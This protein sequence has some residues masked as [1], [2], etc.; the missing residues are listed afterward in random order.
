[1]TWRPSKVRL[2]VHRISGPIE[3]ASQCVAHCG[4]DTPT[5]RGR[6]A[7][8]AAVPT[9]ILR[10]IC[11]FDWSYTK[12]YYRLEY[13]SIIY[14]GKQLITIDYYTPLQTT[15]FF[16]KTTVQLQFCA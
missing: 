11:S 3:E 10:L 8:E 5:L 1:M 2:E 14:F 7:M 13:T 6:E 9:Q 12:L 16:V 15:T 4:A